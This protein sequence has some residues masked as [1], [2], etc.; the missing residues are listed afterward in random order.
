MRHATGLRADRVKRSA[1]WLLASRRPPLCAKYAA[2]M[3][4]GEV[5]AGTAV[6]S[7]AGAIAYLY[8]KLP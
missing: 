7:A 3:S 1:C 2:R 8:T 4:T 6:A 5:E